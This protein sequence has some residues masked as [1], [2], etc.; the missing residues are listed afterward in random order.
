VAIRELVAILCCI[1]KSV[2]L[3]TAGIRGILPQ[4]HEVPSVIQHP[5]IKLSIRLKA[6]IMKALLILSLQNWLMIF[7]ANTDLYHYINNNFAF[8]LK[9]AV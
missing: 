5:L 4:I 3:R 7:S 1:L 2:R 9:E 6:Q 8:Y